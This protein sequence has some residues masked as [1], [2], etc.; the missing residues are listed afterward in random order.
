[1]SFNFGGIND[2]Y[3]VVRRRVRLATTPPGPY[4]TALCRRTHFRSMRAERGESSVVFFFF[5]FLFFRKSIAV[6][7][8]HI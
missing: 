7:K 8:G 2:S 6:F 5:S 4:G 1:M 3:C